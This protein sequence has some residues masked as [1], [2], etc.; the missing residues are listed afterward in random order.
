VPRSLL[1]VA[2]SYRRREHPLRVYAGLELGIGVLALLTL[3]RP[4]RWSGGVYP[5]ARG[6]V[7]L[8]FRA[9]GAG[10]CLLPPTL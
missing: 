10:I 3:S 9:I 4:C 5:R 1:L 7:G 2:A 6:M 8:V